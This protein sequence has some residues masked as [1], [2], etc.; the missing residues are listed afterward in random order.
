MI[1]TNQRQQKIYFFQL[2]HVKFR[3]L[4]TIVVNLKFCSDYRM[5]F[6]LYVNII[7]T[8]SSALYVEGLRKNLISLNKRYNLKKPN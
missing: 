7:C 1:K 6:S 5:L 8:T 2:I 4:K 3:S